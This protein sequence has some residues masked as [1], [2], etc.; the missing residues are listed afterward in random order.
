[1]N[2]TLIAAI[3]AVWAILVTTEPTFA[4]DPRPHAWCGYFMRHL[5]GVSDRAYN[6]ARNWAHFGSNAGGPAV[7]AIVVWNHH[8]GIITARNGQGWVIK[9]GNDGHAVRER[10]RSIRGAIAFRWPG[11]M[12]GL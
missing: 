5:L 12:A 1:M 4:N 3:V 9:S 10:E 2:R 6:L 7:G 8:V 11:R